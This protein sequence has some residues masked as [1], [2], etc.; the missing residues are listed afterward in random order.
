VRLDLPV[1]VKKGSTEFIARPDIRAEDSQ[2]GQGRRFSRPHIRRGLVSDLYISP[3][4][5]EPEKEE[6][7]SAGKQLELK[8]QEK[9]QLQD[10]EITF[11]DFDISGMMSQQNG[12]GVSVGA[13]L[14]VSYKDEDPVELKPVLT[15]G[16]EGNSTKPVRLPGPLEAYVTLAQIQASAGSIVLEYEGPA[17]SEGTN[18]EKTPPAF[19]AEVSIKPG[20]TVLWLGTFLILV[21]G[22]IGVFRRWN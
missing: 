16:K 18:T 12:Q 2:Y 8:K 22:T 13:D 4:D 19:I 9:I 17:A 11:V 14:L 10:Y 5:F 3:V 15:M 7:V 1:D 6:T 20:M 21:G